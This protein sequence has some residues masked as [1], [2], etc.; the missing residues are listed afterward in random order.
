MSV[1]ARE[2]LSGTSRVLAALVVIAA[3]FL[4][5]PSAAADSVVEVVERAYQPLL[6]QYDVPGIAV[7]VT[8]DGQQHFVELGVADRDTRAPVSR[9]TLFEIGSLSKTL[10]A[11]LAGYATARGAL[12]LSDRPSRY[13]PELAGTPIDA[14]QLRNLGT[15]TAGG[16]P[17]QFPEWVTD[18]SQLIEYFR[19]FQ[20][21]AAPG[22]V[23][24]YSNPSIGLFGHAAATALGGDFTDVLQGE[25]L[26]RLGLSRSF[27][28]VPAGALG[29]YAWGYDKNNAPVRVNPGVFDAE[30]YGVKSTAADMIRFVEH[31]IDQVG[32]EPAL[33][34]A[35]Q[36]THT[37]YFEVGPMVQGLGWE[38]YPYPLA[39]DRLLAGN[40]TEMAMSP[41]PAT[42][43]GPQPAESAALFNKT[44]STNGFASYAAFVPDRRIGVVM[45][46]N[47]NFPIPARVTAAHTVLTA[48]AP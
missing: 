22:A 46:A 30:A 11:T 9:D 15:Y 37:G 33:R 1:I 2:T 29:A 41:Q 25:V 7:A 44:G 24:Q 4:A 43:V 40:S 48:L 34:Q 19:G 17:L 14:A 35:V 10:T 21:T 26:P 23:R 27:V 42:P 18:D 28:S 39:L 32:L 16:L 8:V 6:E 12:D 5:A 47:K 20:P 38:R 13:L 45:L 36:A 3:S 31:N